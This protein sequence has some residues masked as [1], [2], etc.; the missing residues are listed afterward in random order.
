M[1]ELAHREIQLTLLEILKDID[2]FCKEHD[3]HYSIAFGTLL[4]AVR[5]K[6]FIP[7]DDDID[8]LMPRPDFERFISTY[9]S[10]RFRCL[11]NDRRFTQY[12]AK[13]EDPTTVCNE[14]K[15][16]KK[17]L[18][19]INV[20]IFPVD[21]KPEGTEKQIAHEKSVA[22]FIRR[23]FIIRRGFFSRYDLNIAKI[24]AFLHKPSYWLSKAESI[25]KRYD[26][27][28]SRFC[29]TTCCTFK[30]LKEVFPKSIFESYTE[31]EFEGVLFPAFEQWDKM[32]RQQYG[33]DYMQLP[34]E[35][36]RKIHHLS[37]FKLD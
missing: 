9:T 8:L 24:E 25:I 10:P 4:G 30:G 26:Y 18:L 37:V 12:F 5:H 11:Y 20:D 34:P 22:K 33:D 21:G 14:M 17:R 6:G 36:K 1:K 27:D 13:V 35:D 19:G 29:G 3:I 28:T 2:A 31:L 7:W 23:M 16:S 15:I 32:L